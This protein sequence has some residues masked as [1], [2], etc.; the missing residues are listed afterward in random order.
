MLGSIFSDC[1]LL[2]EDVICSHPSLTSDLA[3]PQAEAEFE[4]TV[5]EDKL[6]KKKK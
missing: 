5:R 1:R 2:L 6:E 4:I 3:I